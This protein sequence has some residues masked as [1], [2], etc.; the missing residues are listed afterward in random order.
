MSQ[1][2]NT[3][4]YGIYYKDKLVY[5]GSASKSFKER[6]RTHKIGL[7]KN[8]HHSVYLQRIY[9]KYGDILQFKILEICKPND[10]IALEQVYLDS[11]FHEGLGNGSPTAGSMLGYKHTTEARTRM[12][13]RKKGNLNNRY[14]VK[15]SDDVKKKISKS[16]TGKSLNDETRK[17]LS[18]INTG[19]L[20]TNEAK[21]NMSNAQKQNWK[22]PERKND[23]SIRFSGKGNPFYGKTHDSATREIMKNKKLEKSE[24]PYTTKVK[25]TNKWCAQYNDKSNQ[26][27]ICKNFNTRL[28]AFL[29]VYSTLAILNNQ[30][31][32][33]INNG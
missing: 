29:Y 22:K 31:C 1:E 12:S 28:E 5:V 11:Y 18:I 21:A 17:K 10:C 3:G 19:K 15:L 6:W 7:L 4:V 16:N 25:N 20:A 32:E 8:K 30:F 24:L 27:K 2:L 26:I 33:V 13:E 23:A 14:G 9:N